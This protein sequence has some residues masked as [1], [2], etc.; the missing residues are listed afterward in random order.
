MEEGLTRER[1]MQAPLTIDG[2]YDTYYDEL[3]AWADAILGNVEAA[4]DVV[5]DFFVY[6]W[7]KGTVERLRRE[8]ARAYLYAGVKHLAARRA[9][10]RRDVALEAD[11]AVFQE[12]WEEP[13]DSQAMVVE[14]VMRELEKLPPRSREVVE[15]VHLKGLRYAEVAEA[16]GVSVATV[17]TL[18]VRSLKA[19]RRGLS[20]YPLLLFLR[21]LAR[22]LETGRDVRRF[23]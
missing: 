23:S 8:E 17:K 15:L 20:D 14:R 9:R 21:V 5:Q 12:A 18:L 10:G 4:E 11:A 16:L 22:E 7:E 19:L 6:L 1:G 2:L 3:V 13:G